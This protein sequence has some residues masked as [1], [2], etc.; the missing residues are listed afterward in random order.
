M[1]N[2]PSIWPPPP[3][4]QPVGTEGTQAKKNTDTRDIFAVV[5]ISFIALCIGFGGGGHKDFSESLFANVL[6]TVFDL[7]LRSLA[8][9][10]WVA[11]L[12]Q[13]WIALNDKLLR[14]D[15]VLLIASALVLIGIYGSGI[16]IS[17]YC[18]IIRAAASDY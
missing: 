6:L 11:F 9:I 1:S 18:L 2:T 16:S 15:K 5:F 10:F 3:S 7:A 8:I 17:L 4:H 12:K 14:F 13:K